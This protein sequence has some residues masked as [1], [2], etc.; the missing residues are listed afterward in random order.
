[1]NLRVWRIYFGKSKQVSAQERVNN[2]FQ[3]DTS[4]ANYW[5]SIRDTQKNQKISRKKNKFFSEENPGSRIEQL[6]TYLVEVAEVKLPSRALDAEDI[7]GNSSSL[8][9]ESFVEA[10]SPDYN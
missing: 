2:Q 3:Q 8:I 1:M 9:P 10:N 7:Y 4:I 6:D 5:R